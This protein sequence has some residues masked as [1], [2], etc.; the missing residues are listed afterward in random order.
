MFQW[1]S[2][3][4]VVVTA[5]IKFNTMPCH[6][7]AKY[8]TFVIYRERKK[9]WARK[10]K[11]KK[12]YPHFSMNNMHYICTI[13]QKQVYNTKNREEKKYCAEICFLYLFLQKSLTLLAAVLL[14]FIIIMYVDYLY[15]VV[16][17]FL[18]SCYI[19]H[20]KTCQALY[21][22]IFTLTLLRKI[23]AEATTVQNNK[24]KHRNNNKKWIN[25]EDAENTLVYF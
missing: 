21:K 20:L 9:L 18:C 4:A 1:F 5:A 15:I 17:F 22:H 10:K 23:A 7:Y 13:Y 25:R 16:Y 12:I 3:V 11:N 6:A 24:R 2:G 19:T 14:P 8:S